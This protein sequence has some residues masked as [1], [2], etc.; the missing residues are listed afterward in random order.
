MKVDFESLLHR[1]LQVS[2]FVNSLAEEQNLT[3]RPSPKSWSIAEIVQHLNIIYR[4]Y[5]PKFD[6]VLSHAKPLEAKPAT[7]KGSL[8]GWLSVYSMKPRGGKRHWKMKTMK[9][10]EPQSGDEDVASILAQFQ[11]NK[12]HFNSIIEKCSKLDIGSVKMATSLGE[13]VK[14][15]V[16]ECLE[17]VLAH[18]ERHILQIKELIKA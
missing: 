7:Y 10:L 17:F 5:L 6:E 3:L 12:L 14:L 16:P 4:I 11:D 1:S 9:Y 15:Y 18:E 2:D 13:K 8:L